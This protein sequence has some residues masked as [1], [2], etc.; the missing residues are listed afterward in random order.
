LPA[1][2]CLA[3]RIQVLNSPLQF[4]EINMASSRQ[5][6]KSTHTNRN[7]VREIGES[8]AEQTKR[9][10]EAAAEAGQK[11]AQVGADLFQQNADMFQNALRFG[12]DLAAAVM[13]RSTDQL[14]R[15]LGLSS[16]DVQQTTERSTRSAATMLHST[17]ALAKSMSGISQEYYSFVRHQIDSSMDRMNEFWRCR[18]PQ[19]V[20]FLQ[21]EIL[22][23]TMENALQC[24]RRMADNSL[25]VVE[26]AGKQMTQNA[27]RRAA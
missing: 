23:D 25:R 8:T 6:D 21:A 12:P 3:A 7:A 9:M 2:Y 1:K 17:S 19:D 5:D 22:R 26:D 16:D 20:A 27:E 15:A 14:S 11:V 10:G 18:T 4:L 13:R 24:G